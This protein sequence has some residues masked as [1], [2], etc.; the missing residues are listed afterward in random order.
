MN[1]IS[2]GY[3]HNRFLK[4]LKLNLLQFLVFES[5]HYYQ[6]ILFLDVYQ[7]WGIVFSVG[8]FFE[9]LALSLFLD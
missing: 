9:G 2:G 4:N 5:R 7:K 6:G 8:C 3:L 1:I